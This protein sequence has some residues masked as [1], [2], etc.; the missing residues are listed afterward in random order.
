MAPWLPSLNKLYLG[1]YTNTNNNAIKGPGAQ[2][3]IANTMFCIVE[4]RK[5][6]YCLEKVVL[7]YSAEYHWQ[8]EWGIR[9]NC[10]WHSQHIR[11]LH[12]TE[13]IYG[14]YEE[15]QIQEISDHKRPIGAVVIWL[16][17]QMYSVGNSEILRRKA[18]YWFYC[19]WNSI[20]MIGGHITIKPFLVLIHMWHTM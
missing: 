6:V 11:A 4:L 17:E 7:C 16:F 10:A 18:N 12:E 1:Y 19:E 5:C 13:K 15:W 8:R 2:V 9:R 3:W 14:N 20:F